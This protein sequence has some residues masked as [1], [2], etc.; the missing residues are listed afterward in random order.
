MNPLPDIAELEQRFQAFVLNR[1]PGIESA[2]VADTRAGAFERLNVY[3]DAYRLRLLETLGKDYPALRALLGEA[4]LNRLGRAYIDAHPSDTPSVRWFG[5]HFAVFLQQKMPQRPAL[6]ELAA[7]EWAQGEVFDAPGAS[8][9]GIE[10]I[11]KIPAGA[12]PAMRLVLHPAHRRLDLVWN[13]PAIAQA[14]G[15]KAKPPR[16]IAGPAPVAWLLWRWALD[17]HWR[18]LEPGEADALDAA[19]R[20]ASF[21]EICERLCTRIE[22]DQAA[23]HAATLLKRWLADGLVAAA[24]TD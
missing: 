11:A 17:I 1:R 4:E 7:F 2:I 12:W 22:P 23:L 16:P 13:A 18:S 15:A 24:R 5:R 10:D 19:R 6:S 8:V 3:A 20:G 14:V 9:L 21:G